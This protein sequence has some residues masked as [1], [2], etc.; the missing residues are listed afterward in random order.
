MSAPTPPTPDGKPWPADYVS[1]NGAPSD[2]VSE[3]AR[4][5]VVL[6]YITAVALPP[7]GLILGIVLANRPA[8][9]SS[10][11]WMWIIVLSI[12]GGILWS[13]VFASGA[14]TST[15][16]DLTSQAPSAHPGQAFAVRRPSSAARPLRLAPERLTSA[17]VYIAPARHMVSV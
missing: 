4:R 16:N 2:P 3:R 6:G 8:K 14:L 11:H 15:N 12:I 1:S 17:D 13:L 5:L 9:A 10:R 7:I